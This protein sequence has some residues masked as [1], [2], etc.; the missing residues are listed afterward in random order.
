MQ[1]ELY[2]SE[3]G[4]LKVGQLSIIEPDWT[5]TTFKW[6]LPLYSLIKAVIQMSICCIFILYTLNKVIGGMLFYYRFVDSEELQC[7]KSRDI[8]VYV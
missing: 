6:I 4:N 7:R 3:L 1:S 5:K 2:F 8:Y